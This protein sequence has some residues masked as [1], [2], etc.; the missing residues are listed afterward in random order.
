M[1]NQQPSSFESGADDEGYEGPD[2]EMPVGDKSGLGDT[3]DDLNDSADSYVSPA[4][5]A[6]QD[7]GEPKSDGLGQDGTIPDEPDGVAAGYTGEPS[8]FEPEEDGQ[9]DR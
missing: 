5:N 2:V 3:A 1:T 6:S 9:A 4:R 8:T 7:S